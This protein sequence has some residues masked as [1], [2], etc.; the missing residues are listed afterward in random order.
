MKLL[1]YSLA[2]CLILGLTGC[3]GNELILI[4]VEE[5]IAEN[6]IEVQETASGLKYTIE[7]PGNDEMPTLED[8]VTVKYKGF[9]TDDFVFDS[10]FNGAT[11]PLNGV[12]A[13]WQE[14]MQL[15]GKGGKGVLYIPSG[16]AYGAN[17][18]SEDIPANADLIFEVELLNF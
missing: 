5:Y 2:L 3:G 4:S 7:E 6:N 1:F 9:R 13:G 15:F 14:G 11:F 18:P 8:E 12:I 16:L 10:S 17:P